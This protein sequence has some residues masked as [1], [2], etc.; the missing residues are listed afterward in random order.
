MSEE[1]DGNYRGWLASRGG[2]TEAPQGEGRV[3][4]TTQR[5]PP[6]CSLVDPEAD[7]RR[8]P[9]NRLA[10]NIARVLPSTCITF[11]VYEKLRAYLG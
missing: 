11:L 5:N 10:P 4:M 7:R 3:T 6:N 8:T 2:D 1:V 9:P